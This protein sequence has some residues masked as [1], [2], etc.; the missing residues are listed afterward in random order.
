MYAYVPRFVYPFFPS[1]GI[2]NNT[3][4]SFNGV[5]FV[6]NGLEVVFRWLEH[7]REEEKA[8]SGR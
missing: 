4:N 7:A 2:V 5:F 6:G 3:S 8:S 1:T